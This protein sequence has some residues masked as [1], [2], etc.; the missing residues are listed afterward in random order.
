MKQPPQPTFDETLLAIMER[1]ASQWRAILLRKPERAS[2]PA[3]LLETKTFAA[4]DTST[5]LSWLSAA[6]CNDLRVI[7]PASSTIVRLSPMPNAAPAQM[8]AA[9]HLQ[10]EGMFLGSVPAA[11]QGIAFTEGASDGEQLG[12]IMAWPEAQLGVDMPAKLE[13]LTQYIPQPAALVVLASGDLPAVAADRRDGSISIAM[14]SAKGLVLRATRGTAGADASEFNDELRRALAETG[15]N[16]GIEPARIAAMVEGAQGAVESFGDTVQILDPSIRETLA[17]SLDVGALS[18]SS[19]PRWWREWAVLLASAVVATGP[20]ADLAKLRRREES[21]APSRIERFV[22]RY[23]NPARALRVA[24]LAFLIVGLAPIAAAWLRTQVLGWKMPAAYGE[25]DRAQRDIEARI[26]LYNE[27][28]KRTVPITKLLGDLACCTPDGIEIESVQVSASQGVSVKA[29]AKAQGER[30]AAEVVNQ[31]TQLMEASGVFE[32]TN[33]RWNM[34]DGRGI[35][36]F[37]LDATIVN[38]T[39]DARIEAERDWGVKTLA[40]RKYGKPGDKASSAS[41]TAKAE[42]VGN[43][44]ADANETEATASAETDPESNEDATQVASAD[45]AR[46]DGSRTRG[47][48]GSSS[49][50]GSSSRGIGRRDPAETPA[51]A[52]GAS[53]TTE[54]AGA[55]ASGGAP[56]RAATGAGAGGGPGAAAAANLAVP[57]PFS[58]EELKAKSKEEARA[59]LSELAKAKNRPD[60]DAETRKRVSADFKRVLDHL[61]SKS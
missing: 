1:H 55:G 29:E 10:A 61:M 57:E 50:R 3:K 45:G 9:L 24:L 14:R 30:S 32:R 26:A 42:T 54:G 21:E 11:R 37:N 49:D 17:A 53:G 38:A 18:A 13:K 47:G 35:F 19:D 28:G 60:L 56:V 20:L 59:L 43:D 27:L 2:A 12:L 7:L 52:N 23:S 5:I 4:E 39:R 15:L 8:L 44:G 33:W 34:P 25:F 40:E 46:G 22:E 6:K 36:K 41:T 16:A 48:S 58:D 31:M 51:A